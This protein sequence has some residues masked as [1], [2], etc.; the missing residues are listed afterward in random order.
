[1]RTL[2]GAVFVLCTAAVA[3]TAQDARLRGTLDAETLGRVTR[4]VDSARAESLPTEPLVGV[5]LE[6]AQ[7]R[8]PSARIVT[9]VHDYLGALRGARAVLGA[10]SSPAEVVSGAGVLLSGVAASQLRDLRSANPHRSLIVPLVV[11]A[12]L[13]ARG[14]PRDTAGR[15]ITAAVRANARDEDFTA[16]RRFV[17]QDIVAGASPAAAAMLRVRNIDGVVSQ[18]GS[19]VPVRRP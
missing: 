14:V 15:A 2:V 16:L 1:M 8:A 13:V 18:F 5:A 3:A 19:A 11:L 12:D 6:G 4:M 10:D 9:A 17:E 7:R